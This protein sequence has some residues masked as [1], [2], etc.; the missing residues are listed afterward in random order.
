MKKLFT[1]TKV[2]TGFPMAL[3]CCLL[4]FGTTTA[5]AQGP[6]ENTSQYPFTS[7][8]A[9]AVFGANVNIVTNAYAGSEYSTIDGMVAGYE[10]ILTHAAGSYVTVREGA[11]DGAV[12]S[13]GFSPLTFSAVS[14]SDIYVHWN[15]DATCT[16]D[17]TGSFATDITT[18]GLPPCD[19]TSVGGQW[20]TTTVTVGA[21]VTTT[22]A[23]DNYSSGEFSVLTDLVSGNFYQIEHANGSYITVREGAVDGPAIANGFSPVAFTAS[24]ASDLYVHWTEDAACTATNTGSYATSIQDF[25]L[26]PCDM[27]SESGQWPFGSITVDAGGAVTSIATDSYSSGEFSVIT[28]VLNAHEYEFAHANGSYI[29]VRIGAADGPVL[30]SGASPLMVQANSTADLYVHWTEDAACTA[31]STGSFATTVQDLGV[32]PC[33]NSPLAFSLYPA[34]PI[35]PD[36]GGAVTTITTDQ[37]VGSEYSVITG[38]QASSNYEFTH[39][40]GSYIT[41][42]VGAV[43]GPVLGAGF[44]P[45]QVAA[46]TT[47]DLYVHWTVDEF[48]D[49]EATGSHLTTVQ[50]LGAACL[51]EAGTLT[52]VDAQVCLAAAI[53]AV[54]DNAPVVPVGYALVYVVTQD[55]NLT[56]VAGPLSTPTY[57]PTVAGTYTIHAMVIDPADQGTILAEVPNG[58]AAVAALFE[59]NGGTLCGSLDVAGATFTVVVCPDNDDVCAPQA[60]AMGANGPYSNVA[61]TADITD[62]IV[63]AAT[64][65]CN[66]DDGWCFD[67]DVE[68]SVWFTFVAPASGNMIL[69]ANGS[70]FDTQLAVYE[71]VSCQDFSSGTQ[72]QIGANDDLAG[73]ITFGNSELYLCGLT[74]GDTYFVL[75]DGYGGAEGDATIT[76]TETT[77]DAA[78]T[79]VATGLSVDFTDASTTSS[80][81][82]DWAWDF[83]DAGATSTDASPTHVFTADGP[84]TV[85][86]TVTDENG[87]TSEYCEGIQVTDISVG[88]VETLESNLSMYPNPSNGQFVVE[89]NGVDAD[90]QITIM[91]VAGRHV[92]TEGV[93]MKGNFRKEL[94]LNI[95]SGTYLLQINTVEG[96][97]TRKIQIN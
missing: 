72:V 68:N 43:D 75:L 9:S 22:I 32:P 64:D 59:E 36:A 89:V 47:D 71:A 81:I 27:T 48:C 66:G 45:L 28:G 18:V 60:L 51:A 82:T 83:D 10:Y 95:A 15:V 70:D 30:G 91:D 42:R 65:G 58:G 84:Y 74:P 88:I 38:V 53:E 94:N 23:A 44:S 79:Y 40:A 85:C 1:K 17:A 63:P 7:V 5:N 16:Q 90:A 39:A 62:P 67:T 26:P 55:P 25:G 37:Y 6:C 2:L 8:A 12:V 56:V 93:N 3:L 80:T 29:T 54:E 34:S 61:A 31:T 49:V 21:G 69:S 24:S 52:P 97:V 96:K 35:T 13:S 50:F 14:A 11:V 20:P 46:V 78:F 73:A 92:Y 87:C 57:T 19:M 41:V 4:V 77:V 76:L 86:L 33:D